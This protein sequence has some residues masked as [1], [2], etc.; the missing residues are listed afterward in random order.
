MPDRGRRLGFVKEPRDH[1]GVAAQLRQQHLDRRL[2]AE[3]RVLGDVDRTHSA[4]ADLAPDLIAAELRADHV[5]DSDRCY[6]RSRDQASAIAK[7]PQ[8]TRMIVAPD[9][10]SRWKLS[11]RP[12]LAPTA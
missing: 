3:Q 9:G 11:T 5:G 4:V 2:P 10:A 1:V 7:Q 6:R 12:R 8:W